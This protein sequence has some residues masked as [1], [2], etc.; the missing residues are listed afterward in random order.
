MA[1]RLPL[2]MP[3]TASTSTF[4][5]M[6]HALMI[7]TLFFLSACVSATTTPSSAGA[8][9]TLPSFFSDGAVLQ[10]YD[11]GDARSFV[12]GTASPASSVAL[13]LTSSVR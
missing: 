7:T 1:R 5:S 13:T 2:L 6:A 11:E 9:L 10:V 8:T 3:L 4:S 12:Y